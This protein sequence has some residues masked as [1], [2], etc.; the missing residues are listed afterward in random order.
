MPFYLIQATLVSVWWVLMTVN[1]DMVAAFSYDGQVQDTLVLFVVPDLVLIVGLSFVAWRRPLREIQLL[2]VGAIAYA[3]LWC[4]AASWMTHS[5]FLGTTLMVFALLANGF[6]VWGSTLFARRA[7]SRLGS[8]G[9]ETVL[10]SALIWMLFLVLVPWLML[11]EFGRWP[12][13]LEPWSLAA[14]SLLLLASSVVG[15]QS[16]RVLVRVGQGTPL[17]LAAP[18]R[19]VVSGPYRFVRNPMAMA[20]LG[21]GFGVAVITRSLEIAVY[22]G[23]GMIVWNYLVRPVEEAELR[24]TFGSGYD[25]YTRRVRCWIPSFS[26]TAVSSSPPRNGRVVNN[27]KGRDPD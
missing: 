26:M 7:A 18:N 21:Q 12:V 24:R 4:M 9:L 22:V 8:F 14:G 15:V 1:R 2:L 3:A 11:I 23:L 20:G 25:H 17:P 19:L 6:A 5:G 13:R 27:A 10:Q 16:A